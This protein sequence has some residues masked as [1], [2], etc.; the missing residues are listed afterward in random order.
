MC[1]VI[2]VD[3]GRSRSNNLGRDAY[4]YHC[5]G[6][7]HN[8]SIFYQLPNSNL[9]THR[10]LFSR[11]KPQVKSTAPGSPYHIICLCDLFLFAFMFRSINPKTQKYFAALYFICDLFIQSITTFLLSRTNFW[12]R[13]LKAIDNPFNTSGCEDLLSVCRGCLRCV[14]WFSYWFDNLGFISEG[15]TYRRCAASSLPLWGNTDIASSDI[16]GLRLSTTTI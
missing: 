11:E 6:Y 13:Y 7:R 8:Y 1:G 12:H 9:F 5:L 15:N 16:T 14:A 4:I 10:I 2:V 3:A